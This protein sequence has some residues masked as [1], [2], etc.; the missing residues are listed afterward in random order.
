MPSLRQ[1]V[2]PLPASIYWRRRVVA[3]TVLALVLLLVGWLVFGR[4][5]G[6]PKKAG[7][8]TPLPAPAQSIDP[9]ASPSGPAITTR[10]GGTG[11]GSSSGGSSTGGGTGGAGGDISVT[12]GS[13]AGGG[14]SAGGSAGGGSSTGGNSR[15]GGGAS[16]AVNTPE[17]MALPVCATSQLTLELASAQN[18]Y[19]VKDK[20]RLALTI[21]N[22]SGSACRVNLSRENSAIT[23]TSSSNERVWSS[24]DCIPERADAWAQIAGN[25]GVTETFTWDRTRSKPQCATPDPTPAQPGNYLVQADLTIP[26]AGPLSARTSIRLENS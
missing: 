6:D 4:D 20:P 3:L 23:V 12:G 21:R 22:S 5:G 18:A 10:P 19:A 9:G 25:S 14:T 8:S 17:V 1:P 24:A 16:P 13:S 11:G 26:P 2:G 7:S 15:P